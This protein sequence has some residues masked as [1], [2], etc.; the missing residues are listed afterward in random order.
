LLTGEHWQEDMSL[1]ILHILDHSIP[2]QSGYA[3]R[4]LS[5]IKEQRALGWETF[6]LTGPRQGG[7]Q[8]DEEQAGGLRFSRTSGSPW[9][10]ATP[11]PVRELALMARIER[12]ILEVGQQ[13]RPDILHAHSPVLDAIPALRAG[14]SLGIPVVYEVRAF[15]EDAA[16]DHG[17]AREWGLRYRLSRRLETWAMRRAAQVTT[18][19]EGLKREVVSRGIPEA[20]VTVIPNAVDVAAFQF[21]PAPDEHLRRELGL[22]G[23]VVV[24]FVGSFYAYEGLDLL[25]RALG[26]MAEEHPDMHLL[27]VGGGPQKTELEKLSR[28]MNLQGRVTLAGPVPQEEVGRYYSIIDI[29]ALPRY[30]IRL[31]ELV[32]PLKPLEAMAQGLLLVASDIG[33]HRELIRH[34][35]TGILFKPDDVA[36][37]C[38]AILDLR[39]RPDDWNRL[40][41]QARE[42]V[43][44]ERTWAQSVARYTA[45]YDRALQT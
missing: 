1:R 19:C 44:S 26:H 28:A 18:I 24:G 38:R 8:R 20:K 2:H 12:R 4:T 39:A 30:S 35:E 14:H 22:E 7:Y 29:L 3:F 36:A 9:L 41:R 31:T 13:V 10:D 11:A 25:V 17:T 15:W 5:I 16:V 27:L 45:V 6:H 21:C 32:T 42:F 33:G 40:R 43:E 23:R 37:L 34:N